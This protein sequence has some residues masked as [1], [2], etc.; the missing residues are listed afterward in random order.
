MNSIYVGC[1]LLLI[2]IARILLL[3]YFDITV[4][5]FFFNNK[6]QLAWVLFI[7]IGCMNIITQLSYVKIY[8]SKF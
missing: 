5:I 4:H 8:C 6:I 7:H 2:Y 3:I 1:I